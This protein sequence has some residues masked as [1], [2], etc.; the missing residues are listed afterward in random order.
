MVDFSIISPHIHVKISPKAK[1]LALRLDS[2]ARRVNLVIPPRASLKK[3]YAFAEQ[4]QH[5]IADKINN[6]PQPVPYQHGTVIP[7]MG[8]DCTIRFIRGSTKI[9]HIELTDTD[10]VVTTQLDDPTPRIGRYLKTLAAKELGQL[11]HAKAAT[12]NKKLSV[13]AVRDMKSRWGSCSIDGRMSLSWR[14]IFA[15]MESIDYV[16]SHEAA[17]LIHADHGK[18]FWAL[19]ET[20]SLDFATGHAWMQKNGV[21]LGRYGEAA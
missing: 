2:R 20:L 7:I 6:L 16:I 3:A 10:L 17:H 5:W 1:R 8:K 18:S 15:P 11:A 9:T 13:F 12:L 21:N 4:N 19:C 14:L